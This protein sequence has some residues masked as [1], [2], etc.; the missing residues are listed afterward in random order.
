MSHYKTC[1]KCGQLLPAT[2]EFFY[3][4]KRG[5]YGLYAH[6]KQCHAKMTT[7]NSKRYAK[8]YPERQREYSKRYL[9][10]HRESIRERQRERQR[11]YNKRYREKNHEWDCARKRRYREEHP[12]SLQ[13]WREAH[14][15]QVRIYHHTRRAK[16]L[17]A[18]GTHTAADIAA[19]LKRQRGRCYYAACG[20]CKL[21]K[22][23]HIEHV[24]PL[25]R[26]GSRNDISNIVLSCPSCNSKKGNKL[27]H[28]WIEGGR[29]L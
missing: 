19:Q 25:T 22:D 24:V 1:T 23:Y 6:C 17:A 3:K 26:E 16:L 9:N 2:T 13:R 15:E 10:T 28:E 5:L 20:H 11:E 21:G 14:P 12:E 27:P 4:K 7:P 18:E 8:M 29:L